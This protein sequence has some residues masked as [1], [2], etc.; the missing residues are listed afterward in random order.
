MDISMNITQN[1]GVLLW[2]LKEVGM[3]LSGFEKA[4]KQEIC[5]QTP[6]F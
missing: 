1:N 6:H 5:K 2:R 3:N 4:F